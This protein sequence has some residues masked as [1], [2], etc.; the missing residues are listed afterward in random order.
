[1][2][3]PALQQPDQVLFAWRWSSGGRH[4]I[5]IRPASYNSEEGGSFFAMSGY[6]VVP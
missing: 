6:L 2:T 3:S 1:M 5:T 4:V